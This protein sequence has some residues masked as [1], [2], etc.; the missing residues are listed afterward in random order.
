[1]A[2]LLA[3]I[4]SMG[5]IGPFSMTEQYMILASC[6]EATT[7]T[8]MR[9]ATRDKWLAIPEIYEATR[10]MLFPTLVEQWLILAP[11]PQLS[12]LLPA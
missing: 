4:K 2:Q 1:M 11:A 5:E 7:A 8:Q 3:L 12:R 10:F 9:L 6:L